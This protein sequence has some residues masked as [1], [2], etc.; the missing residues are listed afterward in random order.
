M[1]SMADQKERAVIEQVAFWFVVVCLSLAAIIT[2]YNVV[3]VVRMELR[4]RREDRHR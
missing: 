1:R 4:W 3:T 2:V